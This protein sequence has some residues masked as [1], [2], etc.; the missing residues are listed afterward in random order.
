MVSRCENCYVYHTYERNQ[1]ERISHLHIV[2]VFFS[3]KYVLSKSFLA[4]FCPG[5]V[6][7][8]G[9]LPGNSKK[10]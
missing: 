8:S 3:C 4:S 1:L 6:C 10:I 5:L 7:L 2:E 9:G